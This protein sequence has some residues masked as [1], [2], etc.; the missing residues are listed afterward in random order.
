[1]AVDKFIKEPS[2]YKSQTLGAQNG[3]WKK[4][5]RFSRKNVRLANSF[6]LNL[7]LENEKKEIQER[8]YL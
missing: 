5:I 2:A 4:N 8:E 6:P 1:M 7:D 3:R